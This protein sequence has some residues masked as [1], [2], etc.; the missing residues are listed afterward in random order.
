MPMPASGAS[1]SESLFETLAPL[2]N[3]VQLR[4]LSL[5]KIVAA[6]EMP[7][8]FAR[9]AR[10]G[11]GYGARGGSMRGAGGYGFDADSGLDGVNRTWRLPALG[12]GID[13]KQEI[14]S[15][16]EALKVFEEH[17]KNGDHE[18]ARRA[19]VRAVFLAQ[20][21]VN[22]GQHD[23]D[24]A[25]IALAQLTASHQTQ[26]AQWQKA[27][28][29]LAKRIDLVLRDQSIE[30][31]LKQI[32]EA[33]N[34]EVNLIHKS[35]E[36]VEEL[37][38]APARVTYLDL[39]GAR[40]AEALDWVL[41]PVRL[42]WRLSDGKVVVGS[43]RR[44]PGVSAWV[45]DV[46]RIAIPLEEEVKEVEDASKAAE[47][48]TSA[49]TRFID[50]V[51][52]EL[53]ASDGDCVTWFGPG[54]LLVFGDQQRHAQVRRLLDDLGDASSKNQL[55]G[56]TGELQKVTHKREL[57]S[58]ESAEKRET[59][60]RQSQVASSHATFGWQLLSSATKGQLDDEAVTELRIAWRSPVTAEL[61]KTEARPLVLRS[62]WMVTEAA[63]VMSGDERMANLAQE[64][65][66]SA[67]PFIN[68]ARDA[69]EKTPSDVPAF[70]GL[71]Y[72]TLALP[73][74]IRPNGPV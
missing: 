8:G 2:N 65:M 4:K 63:R 39:R 69:V 31:S 1:Q 34:I 45:Y 13:T 24:M 74:R 49:T 35:V 30:Q 26:V 58:R 52:T 46:S 73:E 19:L 71:L 38:D 14:K 57:A 55:K 12:F 48:L 59:A 23:G 16:Q 43:E 62:L 15:A 20:A 54:Q 66:K 29:A 70:Y 32:A 25:T 61:L 27:M 60:R 6:G 64:A 56:E 53:K 21:M 42:S 10:F 68:E 67:R 18:A 47:L 9:E 17:Q 51:R 40:V 33:A 11:N 28:P 44:L 3:A 7:S 72:A 37:M 36:D 41:Q 22:F 50:A 5:G